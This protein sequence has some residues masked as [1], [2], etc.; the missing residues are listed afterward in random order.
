MVSIMLFQL[1]LIH[2]AAN[3]NSKDFRLVE[4]RKFCPTGGQTGFW[5]C[6][7]RTMSGKYRMHLCCV[8]GRI[9]MHNICVSSRCAG[10]RMVGSAVLSLGC[11]ADMREHVCHFVKAARFEPWLPPE[12]RTKSLL[13]LRAPGNGRRMLRKRTNI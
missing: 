13:M 7:N 1:S 8:C 5:K 4:L 9:T 3:V 2:L 12:R 11:D 10:C 6:M